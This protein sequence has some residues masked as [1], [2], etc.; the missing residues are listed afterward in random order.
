MCDEME[1]WV[2]PVLRS[3]LDQEHINE[4]ARMDV[5]QTLWEFITQRG[6]RDLIMRGLG[7]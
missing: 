7:L 3:D 4:R 1:E 6:E 2:T 5:H